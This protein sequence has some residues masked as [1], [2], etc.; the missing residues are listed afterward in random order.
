MSRTA[1]PNKELSGYRRLW[2]EKPRMNQSLYL[3]LSE[4][5]PGLVVSTLVFLFPAL[6]QV[7]SF[8][9]EILL[10]TQEALL[11]G[12]P[13]PSC[14]LAQIPGACVS[15]W[16]PTKGAAWGWPCVLVFTWE[17]SSRS[18]VRGWRKSQ[19]KGTVVDLASVYQKLLGSVSPCALPPPC[20]VP[21]LL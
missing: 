3:Q 7:P 5:N 11:G 8:L 19:I 15:A 14:L 16:S 12:S 13:L 17:E 18:R 6:R 9:P 10:S 20:H 1:I 4:R 21:E 2:N